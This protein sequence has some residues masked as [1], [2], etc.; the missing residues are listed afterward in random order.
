M[1]SASEY[2][3]DLPRDRIAQRPVEP[4]DASRLM[5]L[6]RRDGTIEHRT[7]RDLP[8]LLRK[9]DLLVLNET[10]V[11][12]ARLLGR[13]AATGGR[14]EALLVRDEGEEVWSCLADMP[15][16]VRPGERLHFDSFEAEFRGWGEDGRARLRFPA[17]LRA[18]LETAGRMPL[19]PYIRRDAD[20]MDAQ[21]YQTV[22][23]R[24]PGSIAAPTAGLHFTRALLDRLLAEGVR[25]ARLTL[26]VGPATF[27]P[28]RNQTP[29]TLEPETYSVPEETLRAVR[30]A[31]AEGRRV[32]AVGTTCV[33]ALEAIARGAPPEGST[34]LF[35]RPPFEFQTVDAMVTNFHLPR[36]TPLMMVAAFAGRERILDAYGVAVREGYRFYSYGDAMLIE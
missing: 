28:L 12:P 4:R 19:P 18:R 21:R 11:I 29:Q 5:R 22:Y 31:K 17:D 36:G 25:I 8:G 26:H 2:D 1:N 16:G 14:V 15:R 33:R 23:A 27:A 3:Y 32:V 6:R 13:R 34:G 20:D 35:I 7:F 30:D 24:T 10:K 9:G